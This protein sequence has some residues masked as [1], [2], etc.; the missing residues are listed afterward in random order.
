[1]PNYE[2]AVTPILTCVILYP[3]IHLLIIFPVCYLYK[4]IEL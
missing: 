1:M 3:P 2:Q 4:F